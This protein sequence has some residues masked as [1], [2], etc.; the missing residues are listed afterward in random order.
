MDPALIAVMPFVV[1][2]VAILAGTYA[3]VAKTNAATADK[4]GRA[5]AHLEDELADAKDE[6]ERLRRRIETLE[7]IV[8]T[9]GYDLAREAR[10]AGL[11]DRIDPGLLDLDPLGDPAA[12]PRRRVRE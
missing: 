3:K 10:A 9:E 8:T 6:R 1:A 7:A 11:A 12:H 4:L 2:S 5:T